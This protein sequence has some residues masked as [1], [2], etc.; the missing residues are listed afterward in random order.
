MKIIKEQIKKMKNNKMKYISLLCFIIFS[1]SCSKQEKEVPSLENEPEDTTVVNPPIIQTPSPVIHLA[2]NLDE[3]DQLGYCIDTRGNGFNE[4][5]HA[6]SCK[7]SGGDV[8]FVYNEETLQICSVEFTG[9]CIE[10]S[11]GPTEG[12]SLRLVES[13]TSSSDQK[14][15]YNEDNGEF[16]PEDDPT[17]CLTVGET[18]AAAGIYMFR[19]LTLELSSEIEGK[20]KQ[21]VILE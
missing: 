19:S 17:L 15:I 21:W 12:M 2:D 1:L 9:F 10:M 13:D 8:Q 16:V 4:E 14:F 7:A 3:Q 20:F 6:H 5:L 18:S 11:G